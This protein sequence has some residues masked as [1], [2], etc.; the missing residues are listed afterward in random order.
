MA[1]LVTK[2]NR[3]IFVTAE[4]GNLFWLVKTGERK[5]TVATRAKAKQ[6]AK[7]YLNRSTAPQSWIDRHSA[8]EKR[9]PLVYQGR[10][11]YID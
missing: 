5:G 6:I 2:K 1:L 10:L 7:F 3:P 4:Q 8:P 9:K 11:P